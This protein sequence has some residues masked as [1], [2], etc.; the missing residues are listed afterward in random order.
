M[1]LLHADI[2][3]IIIDHVLTASLK[4]IVS[5]VI[6]RRIY[7]LAETSWGRIARSKVWV[8]SSSQY[9]LA[10]VISELNPATATCFTVQK[11]GMHVY[12]YAGD[13]ARDN[14][15]IIRSNAPF[16]LRI[17]T[18]DTLLYT[19]TSDYSIDYKIVDGKYVLNSL[20]YRYNLPSCTVRY[21]K[22]TDTSSLC[23]C[24]LHGEVITLTRKAF[25]EIAEYILPALLGL[26]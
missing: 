8:C 19:D 1:N 17:G 10:R 5:L 18:M 9:T 3:A 22:D 26:Y 4:N 23:S 16:I 7:T 15:N 14:H 6:N 2:I 20:Q 12:L 21:T 24:K 11:T 25:P 13:G